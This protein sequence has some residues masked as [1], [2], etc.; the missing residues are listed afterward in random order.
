MAP[1]MK[2]AEV[3][4]PI[5]TAISRAKG[6]LF[7]FLTEGSLRNTSGASQLRQKLAQ[8]KKGIENFITNSY[9]EIRPMSIAKVQGARPKIT[10]IDEWLSCDIRENV[11]GAV[12]QGADKVADYVIIAISS[13]EPFAMVLAMTLS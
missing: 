6:P 5:V 4:N 1:T 2:Q 3:I 12:E 10:T 7:K 8:T 11:V 13:R 9:L